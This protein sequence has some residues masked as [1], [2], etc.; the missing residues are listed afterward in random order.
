MDPYIL[1]IVPLVKI[2]THQLFILGQGPK[3]TDV[4]EDEKD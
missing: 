1:W 4:L 3:P 2:D